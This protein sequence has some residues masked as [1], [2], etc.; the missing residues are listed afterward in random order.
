[1]R[2]GNHHGK[3][4][5]TKNASDL[6]EIIFVH[7]TMETIVFYYIILNLAVLLLFGFVRVCK[8]EFEIIQMT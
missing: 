4:N 6:S 3:I 8:K 2:V 1:M 7:Q 5:M